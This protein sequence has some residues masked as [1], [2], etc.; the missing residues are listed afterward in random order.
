MG[1]I[2]KVACIV[3]GK[4]ALTKGSFSAVKSNCQWFVYAGTHMEAQL[5]AQWKQLHGEWHLAALY[6]GE[7]F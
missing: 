5:L 1:V 3:Q 2:P 6:S 4:D 7:A